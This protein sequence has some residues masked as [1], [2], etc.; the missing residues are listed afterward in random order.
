MKPDDPD[1]HFFVDHPTRQARIRKPVPMIEVNK[2]RGAR[3]VEEMQGE[4]WS[5]GAH[6]KNRRR[7]LVWKIPRDNPFWDAKREQLMRIPF[8]AFADEEIAD[9][10]ETLL[11]ILHEIMED[12]RKKVGRR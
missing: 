6:D 1:I 5:L 12:A 2:Q 4:F 9:N 3:Y 11:P 8:L 7:I 10:D